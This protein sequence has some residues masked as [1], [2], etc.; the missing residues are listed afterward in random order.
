MSK[1]K[2]P[3][4]QACPPMEQKLLFFDQTFR[5][6]T[7]SSDEKLAMCALCDLAQKRGSVRIETD[8]KTL[9][10]KEAI[11]TLQEFTGCEDEDKL[12]A[13]LRGLAERGSIKRERNRIIL[14]HEASQKALILE[15]PDKG[16]VCLKCASPVTKVIYAEYNCTHCGSYHRLPQKTEIS[17]DDEIDNGE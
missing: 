1:K 4:C 3:R 8:K 7:M 13:C 14:I 12:D 15:S 6:K 9:S 11:R 17:P 2:A 10:G 5:D 16:P